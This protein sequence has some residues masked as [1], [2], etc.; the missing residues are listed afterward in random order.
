MTCGAY[1][2]TNKING[3][4]YVGSSQSIPRRWKEHLRGAGS[5]SHLQAAFS[6]YGCDNFEFEVIEV[7]QIGLL[8]QKEQYWIDKQNPEYNISKV[9]G[10]TRGVKAS[11]AT[12]TKLVASHLG[13]ANNTGKHW[14]VSAEGKENMRLGQ[15]K[16]EKGLPRKKSE[17]RSEETKQNMFEAR[18]NSWQEGKYTGMWDTRRS[19]EEE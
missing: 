3:K 9:A 7:C 19:K 17:P 10:S 4:C 16:R 5:S 2:I 11:L 12:I 13:V 18:K 15:L 1:K 8:I 14:K 6:K